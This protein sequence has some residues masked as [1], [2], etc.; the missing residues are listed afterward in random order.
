MKLL[1]DFDDLHPHSDVDCIEV[2]KKI[3]A[4]RQDVIINFFVPP[5]YNGMPI[6]ENRNWC[7]EI[8]NYVKQGK[9]SI[10]IHGHTHA[11]AEFA[12]KSYQAAVS[13]IR[14][15]EAMFSAAGITHQK[16]FKGPEWAANG[17][18]IEAL[19]DMGYT[20]LYS[21]RDHFELNNKYADKITIV[22][23]N[24]NFKDKWPKMENPRPV[25]SD[26]YVA[27][28]HTSKTKT[29]NCENSIWDHYEKILNMSSNNA[30]FLKL[31]EYK[32]A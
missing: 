29:L 21:H 2:I 11:P 19:I 18:T 5:N 30:T 17:P 24:F 22:Y 23:Y 3:F 26:T 27:H 9:I 10:G 25:N 31:N 7:K 4:I 12:D 1:I 28:G 16:V 13:S 15:S 8:Q 20:H 14:A 6:Y 32:Y